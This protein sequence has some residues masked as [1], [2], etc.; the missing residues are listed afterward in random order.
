[1]RSCD[2]R[3][4]VLA[5]YCAICVTT[6]KCAVLPGTALPECSAKSDGRIGL[7]LAAAQFGI[8]SSPRP[9]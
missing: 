7:N 8:S 5:D 3:F 9:A 6:L 4:Q 1:M 2:A